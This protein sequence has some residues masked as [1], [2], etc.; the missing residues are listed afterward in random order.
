MSQKKPKVYKTPVGA[1]PKIVNNFSP[2]TSQY[3]QN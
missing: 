1:V 3:R 2:K